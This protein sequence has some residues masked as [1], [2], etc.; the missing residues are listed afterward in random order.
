MS[1]DGT[2]TVK[3]SLPEEF[4]GPYK[5]TRVQEIIC[6]KNKPIPKLGDDSTY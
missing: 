1:K 5:F 6:L 4:S 3:T 2:S